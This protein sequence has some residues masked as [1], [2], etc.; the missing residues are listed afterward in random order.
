TNAG[1]TRGYLVSDGDFTSI[2][3]PGATFTGAY[4]NN[5]CGDIVGRYRDAG[6]VT[7][8]YLLSRDQFSTFDFPG[9][10]FT[11]GAAINPGGD[12]VGRYVVDGVTHGF[13]LVGLRPACVAGN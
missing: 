2:E 8:G 4:G 5:P 9:A 6:G 10:S 7:H 1:V 13:L 11:G 12:L 3:Y